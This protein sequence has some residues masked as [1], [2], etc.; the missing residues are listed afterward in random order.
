M[1]FQVRVLR[2]VLYNLARG[3][4]LYAKSLEFDTR[5]RCNRFKF[6]ALTIRLKRAREELQLNI[7]LISLDRLVGH[8]GANIT[9][10]AISRDNFNFSFFLLLSPFK[11]QISDFFAGDDSRERGKT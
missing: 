7:S 8:A 1:S 10:Y 2:S 5:E 6:A 11:S 3:K 9:R 4:A